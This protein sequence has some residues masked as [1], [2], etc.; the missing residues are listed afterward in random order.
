[1]MTCFSKHMLLVRSRVKEY[2]PHR[3]YFYLSFPH[4]SWTGTR[5]NP[6]LDILTFQL[7]RPL[8]MRSSVREHGTPAQTPTRSYELKKIFNITPRPSHRLQI[9]RQ[10][11]VGPLMPSTNRSA[12][13]CIWRNRSQAGVWN[14]QQVVE[15]QL[16][17]SLWN[18]CQ[19]QWLSDIEL[20]LSS[21]FLL[22]S[23]S[24]IN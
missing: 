2:F 6:E 18:R 4:E 9:W 16:S 15:S 22:A 3:Y 20:I 13:R 10:K 12:R 21:A 5:W 23:D 11:K 24:R 17:S 19:H 8:W 1:L 7:S 14:R